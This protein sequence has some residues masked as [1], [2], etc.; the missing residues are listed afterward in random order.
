MKKLI[1]VQVTL[2]VADV[3]EDGEIGD[4]VPVTVLVSAA[5]WKRGWDWQSALRTADGQQEPG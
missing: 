2:Q 4:I 3:D 1:Q 5:Q